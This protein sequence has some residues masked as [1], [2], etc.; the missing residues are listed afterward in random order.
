ML[1]CHQR[2]HYHASDIA[3]DSIITKN[4]YLN[5]NMCLSQ[6]NRCINS[7]SV[8]DI[9]SWWEDRQQDTTQQDKRKLLAF[10]FFFFLLIETS[11][12]IQSNVR[13]IRKLSESLE[14]TAH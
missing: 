2:C 13:Q 7:V 4:T 3:G 14:N 6:R 12:H 9:G 8:L 11:R 5:V 1:I 10:F